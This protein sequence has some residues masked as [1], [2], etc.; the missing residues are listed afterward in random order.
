MQRKGGR[1]R[2][3]RGEKHSGTVSEQ[4]PR[5]RQCADPPCAAWERG[6][7]FKQICTTQA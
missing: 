5:I 3:D 2:R 4:P 7:L 6:W 1:K